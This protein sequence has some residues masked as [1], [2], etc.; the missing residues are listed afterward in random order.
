[1][2]LR[3]GASFLE[4]FA[5]RHKSIPEPRTQ[6]L[7]ADSLLCSDHLRKANEGLVWHNIAHL[8]TVIPLRA[9]EEVVDIV[10]ILA[11]LNVVEC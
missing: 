3:P 5:Q 9:C 1:M 2:C 6:V 8:V 7:L 11:S 4:S 10:C